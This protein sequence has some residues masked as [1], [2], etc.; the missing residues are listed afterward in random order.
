MF[1]NRRFACLFPGLRLRA[2]APFDR[3]VTLNM[4][5][6]DTVVSAPAGGGAP[7]PVLLVRGGGQAMDVW[8]WTQLGVAAV[9]FRLV[10]LGDVGA[11]FMVRRSHDR[12][13]REEVSEGETSHRARKRRK[14]E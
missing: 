12:T 10:P 3:V 13:V 8:A 1:R 7:T 11:R 4:S 5:D 9:F 14:T 2:A 6:R